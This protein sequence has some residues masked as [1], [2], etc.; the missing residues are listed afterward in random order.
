MQG[1]PQKLQAAE[2]ML[3]GMTDKAIA[4]KLNVDPS[5]VWRWRNSTPVAAVIAAERNRRHET[6]RDEMLRLADDALDVLATI[7]RDEKASNGIRLKAAS[8]ILDRVGINPPASNA[9]VS[10]DQSREHSATWSLE[11]EVVPGMGMFE[12]RS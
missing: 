8:V 12:S 2:L 10:Q 3:S 9:A 1:T 6:I 4:K 5:T 11:D 7:L